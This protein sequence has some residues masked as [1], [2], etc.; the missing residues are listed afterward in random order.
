MR[1][2]IGEDTWPI[3]VGIGRNEARARWRR[4]YGQT[5]RGAARRKMIH[6]LGEKVLDDEYE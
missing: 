3:M 2:R 4:G 5:V 6:C 1:A